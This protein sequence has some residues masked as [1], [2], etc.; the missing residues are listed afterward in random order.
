MEL[1]GER[2]VSG[3]I[4]DEDVWHGYPPLPFLLT[5]LRYK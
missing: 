1:L 3:G 5:I 4:A 2:L